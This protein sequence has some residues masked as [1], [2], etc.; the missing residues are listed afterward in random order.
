MRDARSSFVP[1][2]KF[3]EGCRTNEYMNETYPSSIVPKR[4]VH[5][6][7]NP[8]DNIVARFHMSVRSRKKL[9][10]WRGD[11]AAAFTNN[12]EGLLAWCKYGVNQ[13]PKDDSSFSEEARKTLKDV[14]CHADFLRYVQW[15]NHAISVI[16]DHQLPTHNLFYENYTKDF[17]GTVKHLLNFLQLPLRDHPK[18]FITGKAY[19][20]WFDPKEAQAVARLVREAASPECWALLRHYVEEW[21]DESDKGW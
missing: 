10:G 5:L 6:I 11:E 12:R 13:Y 2:F 1:Y 21:I 14:P 16:K 3:E 7:R 15:H 4:A 20:E 9:G 8:F 19:T 18:P 17:D